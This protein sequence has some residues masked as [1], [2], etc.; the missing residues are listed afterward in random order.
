MR[1]LEALVTMRCKC[2]KLFVL[3]VIFSV[4]LLPPKLHITEYIP[5]QAEQYRAR[6]TREAHEAGGLTVPEPI[7][8][9]QI[10][11]ESVWKPT[12]QARVR[13]VTG[14]LNPLV[15]ASKLDRRC[16]TRGPPLKWSLA[17]LL[18]WILSAVPVLAQG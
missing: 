12:A 7:F 16:D 2:M 15:P 17:L 3:A 4:S 18:A 5:A 1:D 14:S 13:H 10:H 11:Q 9:A 6:L 8:A